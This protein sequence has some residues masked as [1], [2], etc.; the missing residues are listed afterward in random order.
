MSA[1]GMMIPAVLYAGP[2]DGH[3]IDCENTDTPIL[4]RI[5]KGGRL[6]E[7]H[8]YRFANRSEKGRWVFE[9]ERSV[10]AQGV[11][12]EEGKEGAA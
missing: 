6:W 7:V 3:R 2:A 10:G 8:S 1:A 11:F 4:M 12:S 5:Y 9:W